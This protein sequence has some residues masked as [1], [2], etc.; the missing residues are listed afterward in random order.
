MQARQKEEE[1]EDDPVTALKLLLN[2]L[3]K[4]KKWIPKHREAET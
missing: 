1:R 4:P 2:K 3:N